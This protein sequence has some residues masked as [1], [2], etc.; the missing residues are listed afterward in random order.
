MNGSELTGVFYGLTAAAS[1]GTADFSG[2]IA[3]K[4]AGVFSV[5]IVSQI[6]GGLV[7][8]VLPFLFGELL[9]PTQ[10]LLWGALGGVF[11]GMGL[12][13]FYRALAV[14][15]MGVAAPVTGVV[16]VIVPVIVGAMIEG[17]PGIGP[18][19]GFGFAIIAVWLV[20]RTSNGT[21]TNLRELTLPVFAGMGFGLFMILLDR[22][23][24]TALL[25]PLVAVR[26]GS[27]CTLLTIATIN[28]KEKVPA[29]Q[30]LWIIAL[31]GL[32]DTSGNTFFALAAQV[33]RLDAAAVISSLYPAGT[34]LLAW[35]ILKE[36]IGRDQ[37]LGVVAA[38]AAIILI[39]S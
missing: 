35:V 33:G 39:A 30:H 5:V 14:G 22:A 36:Q 23:S 9:P 18:I 32:L 4:R 24:E 13:A 34:V 3:S 16:T 26:I 29:R 27:L 7:L 31:A 25:W 6:I 2:G 15:R 19:M 37:W 1:W 8:L 28:G 21:P 12:V 38:L 20:S 10:D 11:G 17:L